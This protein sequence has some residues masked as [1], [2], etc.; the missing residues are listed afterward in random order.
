MNKKL[1]LIMLGL[2][3]L[4]IAFS[5]GVDINSL[6]EDIKG[7][8]IYESAPN[9]TYTNITYINQFDQNLNTTENVTFASV[10]IGSN[11]MYGLLFDTVRDV[12]PFMY[13]IGAAGYGTGILFNSTSG[14]V[15][16]RYI[17]DL[18]FYSNIE[19][20]SYTSENMTAKYFL[21][22]GSLLTDLPNT[23]PFDQSLNTTDTVIFNIINTTN[24]TPSTR[25]LYLNNYLTIDNWQKV[26]L[27]NFT[28]C[29]SSLEV[30]GTTGENPFITVTRPS[31]DK[32]GGFAWGQSGQT[33]LYDFYLPLNSND[34]SLVNIR[35]GGTVLRVNNNTNN[36]CIGC[37]AP[38][39]RLH[40]AGNVNTT[41][42]TYSNNYRYNVTGATASNAFM[43]PAAGGNGWY[44][45]WYDLAKTWLV[46][47]TDGT[48][49]NGNDINIPVNPADGMYLGYGRG[50][51]DKIYLGNALNV[52]VTGGGDIITARLDTGQGLNELYPMNQ[53]VRTTDTV[54]FA[55]AQLNGSPPYYGW[56]C[57]GSEEGWIMFNHTN[58][59]FQ[60]CNGTG[61]VE[62]G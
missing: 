23:N 22:N 34:L 56:V 3:F 43:A 28:D 17:N 26:C 5:S 6:P 19:G 31:F 52:Y 44:Q 11:S 33:D 60:G 39:Q 49:D 10:T 21:G 36:V 38:S 47:S 27:G 2:F 50:A 8:S 48:S 46:Y 57:G 51:A 20:N 37:T 59:K 14:A 55:S 24:I 16:F 25:W 54:Q 9:I 30:A 40:V 41:G 12:W 15:E 32:N 53:P 7:V 4:P 42:T 45:Y 1:Y 61:W 13:S 62:L 35:T 58:K 18:F 29:S